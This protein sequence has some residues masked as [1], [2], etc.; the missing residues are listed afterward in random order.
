MRSLNDGYWHGAR[1]LVYKRIHDLMNHCAM[2]SMRS[3][4]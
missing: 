3:S 1:E 4:P 2:S